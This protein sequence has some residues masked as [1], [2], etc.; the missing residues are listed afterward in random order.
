M[1]F[2]ATKLRKYQLSLLVGLMFGFSFAACAEDE[3]EL[4]GETTSESGNVELEFSG[5]L[6]AATCKVKFSEDIIQLDGVSISNFHAIGNVSAYRRPFSLAVNDCQL[7]FS[8]QA[9]LMLSFRTLALTD[10]VAPGGFENQSRGRDG[11]L[12]PTGI[13]LAVYDSRDDKNV[14]DMD[15]KPKALVY[16]VADEKALLSERHFYV[17]YMQTATK[18][19]TGPVTVI[20]VAS[21]I[22]N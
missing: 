14:L 4:P 6:L 13:G 20:L 12:I 21:A 3:L 17:R 8:Q 10:M 9:E 18:T 1:N 22:Y 15:G 11:A 5:A 7:P 19:Q 2:F 16:P